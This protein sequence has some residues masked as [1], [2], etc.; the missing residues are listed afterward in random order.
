MFNW[1]YIFPDIVIALLFGAVGGA[2]LA[3]TPFLREKFL[4]INLHGD[5]TEPARN[6][7]G[8]VIS[9]TG[10]VLAF[11]L[12][13]AQGNLRKLETQVGAEAHDID[14]MDRLLVRYGNAGVAAIRAPLCEYARS[15]V[16]DE[17]PELKK[18]RLSE[19]TTLL[20]RPISRG[21]LAIDPAPGRQSLIYAEILKKVDELAEDRA[22]RTGAAVNLKLP[23]IFWET[24]S[25]L[26][27]ILLL[28]AAFSEVTFGRVAALV[29]EGF[30]LALLVALIFIFDQPFKGQTSVSPAPIARV[31]AAMQIRTY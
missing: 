24:I 14:Q 22:E 5:H 11:F 6:A 27:V 17:W 30:G 15:I 31:I 29:G 16:N 1:I 25:G 8:V 7:F 10:V 9:F 13:Q 21:I 18:G 20:F 4:R 19:Q 3:F 2:L 26:L 28:L 23:P 12:V